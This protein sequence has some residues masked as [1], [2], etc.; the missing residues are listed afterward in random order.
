MPT[1]RIVHQR[2]KWLADCANT[3]RSSGY[4]TLPPAQQVALPWAGDLMCLGLVVVDV[5]D[6]ACTSGRLNQ[7]RGEPID[8]LCFADEH[9]PW[10]CRNPRLCQTKC[11]MECHAHEPPTRVGVTVLVDVHLCHMYHGDPRIGIRSVVVAVA[12]MEP[13]K[14]H[15]AGGKTTVSQQG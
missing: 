3:Q 6:D 14:T 10:T 11:C 2:G 9:V 7:H 8:G 1:T 4:P 5:E 13:Q 12:W 15:R